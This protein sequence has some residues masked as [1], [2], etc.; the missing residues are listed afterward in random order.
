[1]AKS[2]EEYKWHELNIGCV[3]DEPGSAREYLTG[4]WR[5]LRPVWDESKC[6]K[7]G[8]C[9]MF[10]P[11]AAVIQKENGYFVADYNY[12]KGCGICS[13]EC[14]PGAIAMTEEEK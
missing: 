7:C 6:I 4:D 9:W 2:M 11:D 5:T 1:M 14:W 13:K 12:C 10:C 3:V 8:V